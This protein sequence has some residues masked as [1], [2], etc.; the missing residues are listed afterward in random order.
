MNEQT[1]VLIDRL[2]EKLGT[3]AELL[4]SVL[5]RQAPISG[6]IDLVT[7]SLLVFAAVTAFRFAKRKTTVP[8]NKR[9]EYRGPA[10]FEDIGATIAWIMFGVV[11][12]FV[13]MAAYELSHDIIAAFINPEYWALMK[14]LKI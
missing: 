3:T 10:E 2:A 12:L 8:K 13:F 1:A 6:V 9:G 14:I 4:W 5:V 11:L 7:F